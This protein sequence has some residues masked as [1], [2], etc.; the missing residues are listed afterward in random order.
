MTVLDEVHEVNDLG[1]DMPLSECYKIV[2][3][4]SVLNLFVFD[5]FQAHLPVT[6]DLFPCVIGLLRQAQ[7]D[8]DKLRVKYSDRHKQVPREVSEKMKR[9]PALAR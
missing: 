7:I 1:Y 2:S 6:G 5:I 9:V 4:A 3:G 8:P